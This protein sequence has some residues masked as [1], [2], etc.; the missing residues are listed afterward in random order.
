LLQ[1]VLHRW[2]TLLLEEKI[3]FLP[4]AMLQLGDQQSS[5]VY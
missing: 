3:I 2:D 1:D 5:T 4:V